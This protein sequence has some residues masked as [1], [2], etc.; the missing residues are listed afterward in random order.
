MSSIL[1]MVEALTTET[2]VAEKPAKRASVELPTL[3]STLRTTCSGIVSNMVLDHLSGRVD[4]LVKTEAATTDLVTALNAFNGRAFDRLENSG[5]DFA[6]LMRKLGNHTN[7]GGDTFIANKTHAKIMNVVNAL[8]QDNP[9]L[10]G[11]KAIVNYTRSIVQNAIVNGLKLS[12]RG[13][14]AS[15]SKRV[16]K[17]N[18]EQVKSE[19]YTPGTAGAQG[20]QVRDALYSLGFAQ[21]SKGKKDDTLIFTQTG[22]D[23]LGILFDIK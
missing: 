7:K 18:T 16:E 15:L 21:I 4:H 17:P 19:S 12:N 14:W 13:V 23:Y 9:E 3:V 5:F 6:P 8:A 10:L 1:N 11:S 20:S 22:V 2:T